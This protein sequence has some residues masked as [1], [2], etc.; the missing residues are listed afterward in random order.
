LGLVS[1]D[2]QRLTTDHI[3]QLATIVEEHVDLSQLLQL[4]SIPENTNRQASADVP[5]VVHSVKRRVRFGVARDEAFCFYYPDNLEWLE[6]AGAEL[7]FFS[8]VHDP[9]LPPDLQGLYLGGGYPEVHAHALAANSAMRAE[10]C[11]FVEQGGLVY[12][13]CGGL[14]YLTRGMREADGRV[15]PFVGIYP[16]FVRMLPHLK[17]LGYVQVISDMPTGPFKSGTARG[18][19]FHYSELEEEMC[20]NSTITPLYRVQYGASTDTQRT[21]YRY[22]HCLASYVHIHFGSNPTWAARLV[23]TAGQHTSGALHEQNSR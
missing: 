3:A 8:P 15:L 14:M 12:A 5:Q 6:R 18:H 22:K 16:T 23:T 9:H 7:V 21:G 1:A 17:A 2:E 20:W 13:E 11:T 4:S 10:V 19:M